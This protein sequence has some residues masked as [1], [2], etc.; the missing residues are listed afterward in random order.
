MMSTCDVVG[1]VTAFASA[2][3]LKGARMTMNTKGAES[4][5]NSQTEVVATTR[6]PAMF[7]AA[8]TITTTS[9]TMMPR[10]FTPNQGKSRVR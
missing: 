5:K 1:V 2:P 4:R 7:N 8:Q 6:M 10:L 9:P 3:Y